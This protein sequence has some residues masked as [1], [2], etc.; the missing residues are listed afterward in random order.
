MAGGVR[1]MLDDIMND[2]E[3]IR[4]Q[5]SSTQIFPPDGFYSCTDETGSP[6][7]VQIQNHQLLE[8]PECK[9]ITI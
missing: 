3:E 4:E 1:I 5:G 8:I 9:S 7:R 6:I 2:L